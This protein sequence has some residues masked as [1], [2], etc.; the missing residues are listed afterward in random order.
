MQQPSPLFL[1]AC[2]RETLGGNMSFHCKSGGGYNTDISLAQTYTKTEAQRAWDHGREIEQPI[3]LSAIEP[4]V[5]LKVDCQ[6]IPHANTFDKNKHYVAFRANTWSGNHLFWMDSEGNL[7]LDFTQARVLAKNEAFELAQKDEHIVVPFSLAD[8]V[9]TPNFE[10]EH[11]NPR[12]M[13]QSKGLIIPHKIKLSRRRKPRSNARF[14]CPC[15][16]KVNWQ[17]INVEPYLLSCSDDDCPY[18]PMDYN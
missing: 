11:F 6:R 9:K 10:I 8:S 18:D 14:N 13:V 1:M 17:P 5:V 4:L 12:T 3:A 16:G 7:S 2:T 15:C